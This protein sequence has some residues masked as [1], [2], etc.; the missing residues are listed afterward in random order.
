VQQPLST[1]STQPITVVGQSYVAPLGVVQEQLA[2]TQ[3]SVEPLHV[4]VHSPI[5]IGMKGHDVGRLQSGGGRTQAP[6]TQRS[7]EEHAFEQAP[8]WV[9]LVM[10]STHAPP[11][12]VIPGG[13]QEDRQTP[14]A[15]TC[16]ATHDTPHVPQLAR[17]V[18]SISHPSTESPLQ[19]A[20]PGRQTA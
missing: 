15:H 5:P 3:T 19:S 14:P 8:Q 20:K 17:L 7:P 12:Q 11:S 6:A 16:P 1:A 9:M 18:T 13:A 10:T 2:L 4:P